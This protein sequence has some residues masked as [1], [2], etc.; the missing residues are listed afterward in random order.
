MVI[1]VITE[2]NHFRFFGK[3]KEFSDE[4]FCIV[5]RKFF[6]NHRSPYCNDRNYFDNDFHIP[7]HY[8]TVHSVFPFSEPVHVCEGCGAGAVAQDW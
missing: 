2:W 8:F 6:T 4:I 5:F 1:N 7:L 3:R